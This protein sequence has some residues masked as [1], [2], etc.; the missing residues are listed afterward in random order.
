M[1]LSPTYIKRA[2]ANPNQIKI[3]LCKRD[4]WEFRQHINKK[5]KIGWWQIEVA[6][7]LQKFVE[8]MIA[9]KK[10]V[11]I[12][13]APPQ[14]GKSV[15]VIDLLA[16]VSGKYPE[17]R[18]IFA[19]FSKR[20]GIR[21]NL[22]LQ[23]IFNS[24][25][26]REIFPDFRLPTPKDKGYSKTMELLEFMGHEGS[27]RNTTAGGQITGESLDF[28]IIDDPIKGRE[29]ANSETIRDKTWEWFT[30]D[31]FTRFSEDAGLLIIG[32]RWHI[33]DPIGRLIESKP[34]NL[35]ILKYEAIATEDEQHRQEGEVLFPELKSL[36]FILA[37]KKV[38]GRANFEAL[39]QQSPQDED[40]AIFNEEDFG[41]YS[42]YRKYKRVVI[43]WDTANK[44]NELNDPSVATVWGEHDLGYDLL[45]VVRDKMKYP[46]LKREALALAHKWKALDIYRGNKLLTVLIED[47]SSGQSLIQDLEEESTFNIVAILPESDKVIRAS[48][49]SP[50]VE[51]GKVFL[52]TNASWVEDYL[53]E[54]TKFPNAPTDDQV[55]STSQFLNWI[56]GGV[57]KMTDDYF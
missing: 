32:T 30:D 57:M 48:T 2:I 27:F 4:F 51:N 25:Q 38:Q 14:H 52:K 17:L 54:L 46:R 9:G 44:A 22:R 15:Q 1:R 43:S 29:A 6:R 37:R 8:D 16:W 36:E 41:W 12:I 28:G 18:Q 31:F 7:E 33:D 42:A 10:P 5:L 34:D 40:G 53:Y 19:S 45:E 3:E 50:Q 55:D 11:L 13:Q 39:Y 24:P 35:K 47:K 56:A 23:K 26:F 49:C 21:A 20:L